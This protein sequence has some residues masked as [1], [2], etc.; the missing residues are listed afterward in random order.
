M[1]YGPIAEYFDKNNLFSSV[2]SIKE[3]PD[4]TII[5]RHLLLAFIKQESNGYPWAI[6]YEPA[7]NKW[8]KERVSLETSNYNGHVSK[9][10]ELIMRS[11]SFG[12]MQILGQTAREVGFKPAYLTELCDPGVNIYWCTKFL[13]L[14]EQRFIKHERGK[15]AVIASYNAG[16]P[17]YDRSGSD[18]INEEYVESVLHHE[19]MFLR[20]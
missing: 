5:N 7:F 4:S 3:G 1:E 6:R 14:K 15:E 19:H 18:F 2:Y 9:D 12:L 13:Y 20:Y 16:S 8:L 10:T 11:C 17:K